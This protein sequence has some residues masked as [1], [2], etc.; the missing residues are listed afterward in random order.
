MADAP[1]ENR[2]ALGQ[3]WAARRELPH[4]L[5][6]QFVEVLGRADLEPFFGPSGQSEVAING[7]VPGLDAVTGRVDRLAIATDVIYILDYKTNRNPLKTL[8]PDHDYVKQMAG[9][10]ALLQQAYPNHDVKPALLWTQ[11]ADVMWLELDLISRALDRMV[12]ETA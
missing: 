12:K 3:I 5:V 4:A 8:R 9:Y 10:V 11:T 6:E 2:I 7:Q 1:P